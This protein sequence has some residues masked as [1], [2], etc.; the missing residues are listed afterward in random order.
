MRILL[1]GSGGFIGGALQQAWQSHYDLYAPNHEELD[2]LNFDSVKACLQ[3]GYFDVVVHTA[4]T[5]DVIH[6]ELANQQIEYNLRMFCNLERCKDYYGKMLYFGSGAEYDKAHY[7]P[8]MKEDYFGTYIPADPY[9]FSKYVMSK[10]TEKTDNVYDLRLFGVFGIGEE[11]RRRF[12]SNMIYQALTGFEMIMDRNMMFDYLYIEDLINILDYFLVNIP[13]YHHYNLC[14]GWSVSLYDLAQMIKETT[15][16]KA[17]IVMT[18]TDWKPEYSGDNS[19]LIAEYGILNL[20]PMLDAIQQMLG[21]YK[22]NGF[23]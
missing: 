18:A 19:R 3:R 16:T 9:G 5:N 17:E 2:L 6:P 21:Y 13:K 15:R 22:K 10:M 12:I 7:I 11:W 4:N 20:T 14:S 1:T 23:C 8:K